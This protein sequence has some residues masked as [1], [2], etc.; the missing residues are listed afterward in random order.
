M[1]VIKILTNSIKLGQFLKFSGVV[2]SGGMVKEFLEEN[3][4]F[5]NNLPVKNRGKQLF[6]GDKIQINSE[7]FIIEVEKCS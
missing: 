1:K 7:M 3:D 5:V 2:L 4:V 6:N